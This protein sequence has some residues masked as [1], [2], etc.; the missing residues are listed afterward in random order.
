MVVL[1]ALL[2]RPELMLPKADQAMQ[3]GIFGGACSQA[4]ARRGFRP[5]LHWITI[6][7]PSRL[8]P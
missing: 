4:A 8:S 5:K 6:A 3:P 7:S 1:L 2:D